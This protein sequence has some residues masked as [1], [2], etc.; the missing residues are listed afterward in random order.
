M[1]LGNH[2]IEHVFWDWN[3][4]LL[5]D[6]NFCSS[7]IN[8]ILNKHGLPSLSYKKY[9][10]TFDFPVRTY[11]ERLGL[12]GKGVSF[13]Q[14]SFEFIE[15]YQRGWRVC[16]LQHKAKSTLAKIH[17]LGLPQSIITAG[18]EGL[19]HGFVEHHDLTR[20]FGGLIGV[21]HIYA[22]GK[23]ERAM[24]YMESLG[25]GPG[26]VLLIGDTVHDSEVASAIGAKVLLYSNGHHPREKLE[27][28]GSPVISCLSQVLE[29]LK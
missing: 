14:T 24:Q 5:D 13:E 11:Y 6:A 21:D 16:S 20:Y 25:L 3:G 26:Q 17:S 15:N 18:K 19:L 7:V 10:E 4:T 22:S 2:Q 23:V 12:S 27:N 1:G 9:R 28:T 8:G 29:F